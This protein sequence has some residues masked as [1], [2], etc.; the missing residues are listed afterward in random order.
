[1]DAMEH[2]GKNSTTRREF[3]KTSSKA[4]AGA[5]LTANRFMCTYHGWT[6]RND[7]ALDHVPG[8]SEAYYDALVVF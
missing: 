5:A 7:G 8:K 6:Y 3:L 4:V 2:T 1:M